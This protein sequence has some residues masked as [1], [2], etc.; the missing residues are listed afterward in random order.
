MKTRM[1]RWFAGVLLGAVTFSLTA[2]PAWAG[3]LD[4]SWG[5]VR[6]YQKAF[7]SD[8]DGAAAL[9]RAVWCF[10][11]LTEGRHQPG[12]EDAATTKRK[13]EQNFPKGSTPITTLTEAEN[14][15]LSAMVD[16][17]ISQLME[18]INRLDPT[19]PV[20]PSA[21]AIKLFKTTVGEKPVP[22]NVVAELIRDLNKLLA[23]RRSISA[24]GP[25]DEEPVVFP[26]TRAN[27]LLELTQ[28][29]LI[30]LVVLSATVKQ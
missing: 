7:P 20:P 23:F 18:I 8:K 15:A 14:R 6:A 29:V 22:I 25:S 5:A 28:R 21:I 16:G 2:P 19:K 3:A 12:S 1:L 26:D 9:Q 10:S 17:L 30:R 4:K 11:Y 13:C 27:D 24:C